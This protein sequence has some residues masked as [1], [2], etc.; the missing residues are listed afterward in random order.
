MPWAPDYLSA[1]DAAEYIRMSSTSSTPDEADLET[2]CTAA[3]RAIDKKTNRQ[4]GQV[5]TA[6]ARTYRRPAAFDVVSGL[7]LLEVDDV[8]D[9]TGLTVGGVPLATSGA[10]LLP[11]EAPERGRPY[12]RI[13]FP[14]WPD[15]P[16]VVSARWGWSA[17]PAGVVG[18]AK[19]QVSRWSARRDS[20]YG[21]A[22]SPSDGSELRLLARLDPDVATTLAGLSRRRRVG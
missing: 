9:P 7:W 14:D 8:Q 19:L 17:V 10:V 4:F 18:A 3:S 21:V 2:W 22:G 1:E 15:S 6:T 20:P 11:D 13:G 12:E 5:D 16:V